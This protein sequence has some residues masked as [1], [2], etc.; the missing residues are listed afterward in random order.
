[1]I[2]HGHDLVLLLED[3]SHAIVFRTGDYVCASLDS[4]ENGNTM[5]KYEQWYVLFDAC[6]SF[7][8]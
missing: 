5:G 7:L 8:V 1:M 3:E 4:V 6:T 2:V